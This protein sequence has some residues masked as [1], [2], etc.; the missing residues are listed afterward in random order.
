MTLPISFVLSVYLID[1]NLFVVLWKE[2]RFQ[3]NDGQGQGFW[4]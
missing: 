4:R 1:I 2:S 3:K